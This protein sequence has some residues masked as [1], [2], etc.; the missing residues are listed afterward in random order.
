MNGPQQT[1]CFA[2][3]MYTYRFHFTHF[4][5]CDMQVAG[6]VL[7]RPSADF[8]YEDIG[9]VRVTDGQTD[10]KLYVYERTVHAHR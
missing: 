10:R 9:L 4:T 5:L 8:L 7:V 3:G 2:K 1:A 6:S